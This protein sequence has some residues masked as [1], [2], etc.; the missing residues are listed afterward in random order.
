MGLARDASEITD[1]ERKNIVLG[2]G[3]R[4]KLDAEDGKRIS[5][6]IKTVLA[7]EIEKLRAGGEIVD[8]EGVLSI[9]IGGKGLK[10]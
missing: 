7:E 4:E 6:G 2:E 1:A 9:K 8:V 10:L 3:P 5:E